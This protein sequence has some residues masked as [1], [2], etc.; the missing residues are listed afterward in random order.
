MAGFQRQVA[1]LW[2]FYR[3]LA[4]AILPDTGG[5]ALSQ[6]PLHSKLTGIACLSEEGL[7]EAGTH[8]W[9]LCR[10]LQTNFLCQYYN[11]GSMIPE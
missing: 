1:K 11:E 2:D 10:T 6:L 5:V 8:L 9:S 4:Q 3:I 7:G